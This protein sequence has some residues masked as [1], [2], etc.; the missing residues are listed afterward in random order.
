L[1]VRGYHRDTRELVQLG[2]PVCSNGSFSAGPRRLDKRE[3]QDLSSAQWDCFTVDSSDAVFADDDGVIFLPWN[4]LD[5]VLKVAESIWK[6]ERKRAE[7]IQA[8]EKLSE[9]FDLDK[10]LAKRS[11][12]PSYPFRKHLRERGAA[13]EELRLKLKLCATHHSRA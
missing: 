10:Y 7:T 4:K 5:P 13:V 11:S 6:V 1:V 8:G 2:L 12:D 3:P 9:Q